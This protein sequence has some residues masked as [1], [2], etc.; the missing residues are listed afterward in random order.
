MRGDAI[1]FA[2]KIGRFISDRPRTA[3][4]LM[5]L[6]DMDSHDRTQRRRVYRAI[7]ALEAAEFFVVVDDCGAVEGGGM[8]YTYHMPRG[9]K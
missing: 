5:G 3:T 6:L 2:M 7:A 9:F 8:A 4:E 1:A